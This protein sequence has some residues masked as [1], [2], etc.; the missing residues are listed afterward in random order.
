MS[1]AQLAMTLQTTTDKG[2]REK[3]RSRPA[4]AP[5]TKIPA[6]LTLAIGSPRCQCAGCGRYFLSSSAFDRHQT[7]GKD[8][9]AIC[10]DPATLRTKDKRTNTDRPA[11][12][13]K[14]GWWMT[15]KA[16]EER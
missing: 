7:L 1:A 13:C 10:H 16:G 5:Q 8:G 9:R 11:M 15:A 4:V 3:T 2:A 6:S 12:V 14:Q